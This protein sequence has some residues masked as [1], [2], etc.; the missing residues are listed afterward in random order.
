[1]EIDEPESTRVGQQQP[2]GGG[3]AY[4]A[5]E[6]IG[7]YLA[8]IFIVRQYLEPAVVIT[9]ISDIEIYTFKLCN[10]YF[11]FRIKKA[12]EPCRTIGCDDYGNIIL[13][14]F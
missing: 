9:I 12:P 14:A 6:S 3:V 4:T 11:I 10:V 1:M 13:Q 8:H 7:V 5:I 2:C